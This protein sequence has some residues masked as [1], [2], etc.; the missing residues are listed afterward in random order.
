MAARQGPDEIVDRASP[1]PARRTPPGRPQLGIAII[2]PEG[3]A[4]GTVRAANIVCR[5]V[6]DALDLLIDERL[7]IAT[8]RP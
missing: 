5:S 2:D 1:D 7:L 6:T 3:A 4:G 8:L